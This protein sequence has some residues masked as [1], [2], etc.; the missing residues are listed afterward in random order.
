MHACVTLQLFLC[1]SRA[2]LI[3]F[4]FCFSVILILERWAAFSLL[5][6]TGW[7]DVPSSLALR[8]KACLY[9]CHLTSV[10]TCCRSEEIFSWKSYLAKYRLPFVR[11]F[12]GLC[13]LHALFYTFPTPL[14]LHFTPPCPPPLAASHNFLTILILRQKWT[15]SALP[16][17]A[18]PME[19][20][21]G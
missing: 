5:N 2:V 10:V 12:L 20:Q 6:A 8:P 17:L 4:S 19:L 18:S 14:P 15:N 21:P 9:L 7:S 1:C 3:L 11:A 13:L 16:V